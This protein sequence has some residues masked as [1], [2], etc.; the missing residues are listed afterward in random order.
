MLDIPI[1]SELQLFRD[2]TIIC[3]TV[4]DKNKVDFKGDI[5]SLSDAALQAVKD[6][7]YD[8]DVASGPWEWTF[9][10]KRL[11]DLRREIEERAD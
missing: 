3:K 1:G 6:L 7:G 9:Q 2:T 4:D 10:G 11:D 8:W 5:T